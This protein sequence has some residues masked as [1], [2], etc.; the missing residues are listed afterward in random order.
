MRVLVLH[1]DVAANAPPEELDTL[2]ASQ[3]IADA[4]CKLGHTATLAPFVASPDGVRAACREARA[5]IVFNMVESVYGQDGLAAMA[6][7]ILERLA[8]PYTGSAAAPIA[9]A[10]NKPL[11]KRVLR[12]AGLPT[13]DWTEPPC[14]DGLVEDR[15]YVVKSANEDAS[16]GLDDQAVVIGRQAVDA[17]T[18]MC[19]DR[20]GG[21]WFAERYVEG[22]EF[23]VALIEDGGGPRVLPIPEMRFER[24]PE[25]H[26]RIIGYRA[27]WDEESEECA[28]TMRVFGLEDE[29]AVLAARLGNLAQKVW[30]LFGMRGYIR[31][32]FRVDDAGNPTILEVNPNPCLEP[33]VGIAMAAAEAGISYPDLIACIL[34]SAARE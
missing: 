8:I 1:S 28:R 7:S 15:R 6:P 26:A 12:S 17:R 29:D 22:R 5:E 9:L 23:N 34:D 3:A 13:P 25:G 32:D 14:W 4:L 18:R 2:I 20:F 33:Q 27:K 11:A 24:W 30:S 10:G 19:M 16:L 31:V 21:S